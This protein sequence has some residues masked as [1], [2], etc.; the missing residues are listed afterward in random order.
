EGRALLFDV[1]AEVLQHGADAAAARRSGEG[2]G[3]EVRRVPREG[4]GDLSEAGVTPRV[5][6]SRV[7]GVSP[8][9]GPGSRFPQIDSVRASQN[10]GNA[11]TF[12]TLEPR[13]P[14]APRNPWNHRQNTAT[15]TIWMIVLNR[16]GCLPRFGL[17]YPADPPQA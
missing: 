10:L 9:L 17:R 3:G 14:L 8:V 12:G 16:S 7:P 15:G 5:R 13:N 11:R 4:F 2:N 1:R 6:G